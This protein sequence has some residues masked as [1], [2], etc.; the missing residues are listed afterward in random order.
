[1]PRP[2]SSRDGFHFAVICAL[3]LEFDAVC[4]SL[5]EVWEG[6]D[7][8]LGKAAGD[9]NYYTLGCMGNIPVVVFLLPGKGK[10]EAASAA[11]SLRSSYNNLS[12]VL[13]VGVCGALPNLF[14]DTEVLLGDVIVS[15]HV[16][17]YDFGGQYPDGF[18]PKTSIEDKLGRPDKEA[19]ILSA[20]LKTQRY[21]DKLE[22]N[23][24]ELLQQ[25]REKVGRTK[26]R[27]IYNYP[28]TAHDKLF[29]S[30]YRHKHQD[31]DACEV[32]RTCD[33]N[34]DPVCESALESIC[35]DLGCSDSYLIPRG[36]LRERQR[37]EEAGDMGTPA[38]AIHTGGVGSADT[39][40][41]SGEVRDRISKRDKIIAFEMEGAGAWDELPS[42]III[43]GVSDYADSHKS[44]RWQKYAAA[45]AV[46]TAKALLLN[47]LED[48]HTKGQTQ[49]RVFSV[50]FAENHSFVGREGVV[51]SLINKLFDKRND[52]IALVGMGGVGKTQV[53]LKTAYKMENEE[54][55]CSI[56][57]LPAFSMAGFEQACTDLV[58][59]LNLSS[60]QDNDDA[61]ELVKQHLNSESFGQWLLILDN[62]DSDD[63]LQGSEGV[64]GIYPYLPRSRNGQ[65]LITTRSRKI[66]VE[67]AKQNVIEITEMEHTDAKSLLQNS[68]GSEHL[69]WE[70]HTVNE[71]LHLLTYLP[72]AI[73]QAAA[74]MNMFKVPIEEYLRL[75]RHSQQDMME[76]M[77]NRYHDDTLYHESQGAVATT[78]LN[79][80]I[81]LQKNNT[82]AAKLLFFIMWIEPQ[83]IPQSILPDVGSEQEKVKA[84]GIL[85]SLGFLRE[86]P[87]RR[88]FDMHSLMHMLKKAA[89]SQNHPVR[90]ASQLHLAIAYQYAGRNE[91]ATTLLEHV[92][93]VKEATLPQDDSSRLLSQHQ[94]AVAYCGNGQIKEA[95]TLLEHVVKVKEATLPQDNLSRL[96]SQRQLAV[97]YGAN[98]QAKEAIALLEHVVKIEETMLPQDHLRRLGSQYE[99][100]RVYKDNRRTKEAITLLEHVV[101]IEEI[102]LPQQHPLRVL[103]QEL[104]AVAYDANGQ[105]KEAI[106]LREY[107]VEKQK[108]TLP[109]NRAKPLG[110]QNKLAAVYQA[111][112]Q[113]EE[114]AALMEQV[115]KHRET[116]D[117]G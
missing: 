58:K 62:V 31:A 29:D 99:L 94:L 59:K 87:K 12:V 50:P 71:L 108:I 73:A 107:V 42:C 23:A 61:R 103:S 11:A 7:E 91:E 67:F 79:S 27:G 100:A 65:V 60:T 97:A 96:V 33:S 110:S 106:T 28:G 56:L 22:D 104:L 74:Y 26:Y 39:V 8:K 86:R 76:L 84:I 40:M 114:A 53:A 72:L 5:D 75:C 35:A 95:I 70:D 2:P 49:S 15:N 6:Q 48:R 109:W 47:H 78:W 90:L 115:G 20:L 105:T 38:L 80:F 63:V 57:W 83:A 117:A 16:V 93:K 44:K 14:D 25:L 111:N 116:T 43:K 85:C 24:F 77:R 18:K 88:I 9:L 32:C 81:Q 34:D 82:A 19:R 13:V 3:P 36:R 69:I 4:H 66:A 54:P 21:R 68:L 10:V 102:T 89:L 41:K 92:V 112:G 37:A 55:E 113:I 30:K 46:S 1:M 51:K 45:T 17:Q 64:H 52:R 101:K 98:G